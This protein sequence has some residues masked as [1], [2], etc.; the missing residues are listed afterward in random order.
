MSNPP[1]WGRGAKGG[2]HDG[3]PSGGSHDAMHGASTSNG[4]AR[5]ARRS[6]SVTRSQARTR[7]A[8]NDAQQGLESLLT[9]QTDDTQPHVISP[10]G[11]TR[12]HRRGRVA[13][14]AVDAGR[15]TG[16]GHAPH[17][18]ANLLSGS[19]ST[20]VSL[21]VR[22]GSLAV[23]DDLSGPV[24]HVPQRRFG[25]AIEQATGY[26]Q[27]A[28]E[29][30]ML[31]VPDE[32]AGTLGLDLPDAHA[33]RRAAAQWVSRYATHLVVLLVVGVLVC[34]GG[35]KAFTVQ[36][37]Y[38]GDLSAVGAYSGTDHDEDQQASDGTPSPDDQNFQLTLPR[39]ELGSAG[40]IP[41]SAGAEGGESADGTGDAPPASAMSVSPADVTHY[42]VANGD[43]IESIAGKFNV[44]PETVMGSNG[45]F[46]SEEDLA[47][48]RV[49]LV[50]PI[51]AMYY[52]AAQGDTVESVARRF[53]VEPDTIASYAGNNLD[54]SGAIKEGQ[55]LLVPG[56]MMPER[57]ATINYTVK[58]GDSLRDIA[59]RFG[60]DVPTMIS[61]NNIPDADN[62]QPGAQLRVLPVPGMEYKVKKGDTINTIADRFGV[63]PQMILDYAP[64]QLTLQSTLK[65]DKVIMVPGGSLDVTV[66][67]ARLAP[68]SRGAARPV[69]I[70]PQRPVQP[71]SSTSKSVP[72]V[73]RPVDNSPKKATGRMVWPVNGTITQYFSSH[74]NG[75]D[76]AIR[77]GTPIH[78]ADAGRVIWS[79]W[80]TD[81]LGYCVMID[82][83]N[84]LL[85]VYGHMI[86]QPSVYVGQ[87]VSRGQVIGNIGSTGHST[88]P[89]VHFMV[90]VGS[91]RNYRNPLAY[92]GR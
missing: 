78:A 87:Y 55:P 21:S 7:Q 88:G 91:G 45:I 58:R 56:G 11:A 13:G 2:V 43:T 61:S 63:T 68:S 47:P 25:L 9:P 31:L 71:K 60:V 39:T 22:G 44:L 86:R 26:L 83:G 73:P 37:A 3:L 18:T 52:V 72:A 34:V 49:L 62:L 20:G 82:H 65:I 4:K 46:D 6:I 8:I 90:K 80:R 12:S 85:T 79:G 40:N 28:R 32:Q 35:F 57:Q 81:G 1:L 15:I 70:Q 75:L 41:N 33:S 53:Q 92:L 19:D 59:A 76:I 29:R 51:D 54:S 50:P 67:A 74:H 10:S 36:S 66:A 84:G 23:P 5:H 48:G 16:P 38:S 77:A 30:A 14:P 89:H 17:D 64:N 27:T 24:R 69:E 42:V